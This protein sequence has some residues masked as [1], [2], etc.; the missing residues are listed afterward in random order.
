MMHRSLLFCRWQI[1]H[2]TES[3][4]FI[5]RIVATCQQSSADDMLVVDQSKRLQI[6]FF[7]CHFLLWCIYYTTLEDTSPFCVTTDTPVLDFLVTSALS[8]K[9]R[10][11]PLLACFFTYSS[12]S[13]LVQLLLTSWWWTWQL[14]AFPKCTKCTLD[15]TRHRA[16][17]NK[18]W[19]LVHLPKQSPF[20][21]AGVQCAQGL[22]TR[23]ALAN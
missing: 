22:T 20:T 15:T 1:K 18:L 17:Y 23:H 16:S 5:Y 4:K 11:D 14:V 8:F 9:V 13:P 10:V 12:E 21:L 3:N 19:V 6:E 7:L 2:I